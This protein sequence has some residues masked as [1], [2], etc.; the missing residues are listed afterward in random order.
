MQ[1]KSIFVLLMLLTSLFVIYPI[2][3][4]N[5][6]VVTR[7]IDDRRIGDFTSN[8]I[9]KINISSERYGRDYPEILWWYDLDAPCFGSAA[10]DDIDN[11]GN[12]ELV[13]GT[14]FNDEHV[15]ALN[16][17]NGSLLWN[18]DTGGC[19]D[20]S[21]VIYDVDLDGELEVIIPASSPYEV[22][23][24]DGA[25]G[26]VEWS[27]STGYPNCIDSPQLLQMLIMTINQKLY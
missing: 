13:F 1:K 25:T 18:Y 9:E 5:S 27:R 6:M 15:Y 12:L 3:N 26:D 21:P 22:Y 10:T 20:A 11:D 4:I 17:N 14:Y 8:L 16:A 2:Q 24:F 19:N 7:N 23:C